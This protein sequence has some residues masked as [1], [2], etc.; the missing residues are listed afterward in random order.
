MT[1][2]FIEKILKEMTLPEKL[3]QLTQLTPMYL[4]TDD[5]IDLTG[6]LNELRL[7]PEMVCNV[8]SVLNNAGAQKS[9]DLQNYVLA[10][11]RHKIPLL[12]MADIIHGFKTVFPIPL[13]QACSF[14]M[15]ACEASAAIAAKEGA[16]SGV[17]VTFSP[18]A[19]LVRDPRWGRVME[20][21]GEDP[22]LNACVAASMVK[23]YQGKDLRE[24]GRL[25]ACVKHFAAYGAPEG[26]REYN[27][28]DLSEGVLREFYLTAYKAAVDAGVALVMAAFNTVERVPASANRRLMRDVLRKEWGFQGVVIS[29]FNSVDETI[30]HG[31]AANH[32]DAAEKCLKAGVD[33]EMMSTDYMNHVEQLIEEKK[34]DAALVDEAVIRILELKDALGLFENPYKDADPVAER[35]VVLCDAHLRTAR[36]IAAKSAVLLKNQAVLPL[37]KGLKIGLAGPFACSHH[38][39]GGWSIE[40]GKAVSLYDGL[41]QKGAADR[42]VTAMTEELGSMQDGIFDVPDQTQAAYEAL[43]DCDVILVAVGENPSDTGEGSS[44]SS[45]RLSANQEKLVR[46]LHQTGKP[47]ITLVF[48]GRP[49]EIKPICDDSDAVIQAWFLGTQAGNALADLLFGDVNPSGRLAMSFPYTVGQIPVYY[50][51]LQ[52]GRPCLPGKEQERYV[53]RYLDCPNDPLFCF[54]YGLSYSAFSYHDFQV[55]KEGDGAVASV[56]VENTSERAGTETVQLYIHDVHASVARPVKELK[57][58]RQ[59]ALEPHEKQTVHFA[60]TPEMLSFYNSDLHMTFEHGDFEIMIGRNANEVWTERLYL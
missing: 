41:L 35:E 29:D 23:G 51:H 8:G 16:V 18:M 45:L 33:I 48:S 39:E 50:N 55:R 21:A 54:G 59:V 15:D 49:M 20:A 44:K 46:V 22:Y 14:D 58:F 17:H 19:D 9:I 34:L 53:S 27:T 38:L 60:I 26:G 2:P 13:A 6:P 37:K 31:A 57:G 30:A 43:Q 7:Q 5:S 4:G 36:E 1:K 25:A 40:S 12:L 28:V 24:K 11:N 56:V 52:T 47:V 32:A 3:A 42:I 10:H